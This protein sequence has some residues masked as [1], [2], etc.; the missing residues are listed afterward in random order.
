MS[1]KMTMKFNGIQVTWNDIDWGKTYDNVRRIQFRI[2]KAKKKGNIQQVHWLQNHLIKSKAAK[3]V[4]VRQ[5]TTLNKSK[6]TAGVDKKEI[7]KPEDKLQLAL[8]L[9]LNGKA[10]P[11]R[12]V[13]PLAFSKSLLLVQLTPKKSV[14]KAASQGKAREPGK[15]I[16]G[17]LGILSIRDRAKQA[18]ARLALEPEWEAIFEPNSYG[19][20]PGRSA[21]DAMEAIFLNLSQNTPKLVYE[22]D[23][24]KGFDQINHQALLEKLNTF[25]LMKG[26]VASWLKAGV[27]DGYA[28]TP[29]DTTVYPS[30]NGT[31]QGGII[32]PLLANIALHGL[33]NHLNDF[34]AK[35]PIKPHE[36]ANRG[37]ITKKK[38][39]SVIRYADD[40]VL[41]HRNKVILEL[42]IE[43]TQKWL[44]T[45]GLVISAEK[46]ALCDGRKGFNF[47]G[48]QIIQVRKITKDRFKTKIQPSRESQ[49]K[50]LLKVREIII[51]NRSI[52]SY[53]LILKLRPVIIGWANYFKYCECKAV[54]SKLTHLI[55]QK[56][57]AW[58]FR[59]DT[60]N[61]KLKVKENYFPSG[62]SYTYDSSTHQDNWV[63]VGRQKDEKKGTKE[64]Y[65]PHM[66]W[67]KSRKHVKVKEDQSPFNL[68]IYWAMRSAKHSPY[69][70]RVRNLLKH[71]KQRCLICKRIFTELD[72]ATWEV[73]HITPRSQGGKDEYRNLQL[74]HK[75]CHLQKTHKDLGK[76]TQ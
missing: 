5:V 18:L 1:D 68:S 30:W 13:W 43:E 6:E 3:L 9:D 71:Q 38:A 16:M 47:L 4:A 20:R 56:L 32:S 15:K 44:A 31:P 48:F 24:R 17:P 50:L 46:S 26:Q 14:A 59:R 7:T 64:V 61:G 75:S 70:L 57:R 23:I 21:H 35:L 74:L 12:R 63:L 73:D 10:L 41:I 54:F 45:I 60:R 53:M 25:P 51:Q 42:C 55:F 33:E 37:A 11:I 29:K 8:S 49:M 69:P 76:G 62:C 39:L 36:G 66:V 72:S 22:A 40:F 65:L 27:M 67:V 58:V 2:Y 19:F 28:N 34:V 52:S